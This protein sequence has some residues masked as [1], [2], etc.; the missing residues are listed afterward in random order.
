MPAA[1]TA[2]IASAENRGLALTVELPRHP[3]I[4][5]SDAS[6]ARQIL[7]N[8]LSNAI[9]YTDEGGVHVCLEPA[10]HDGVRG[11]RPLAEKNTSHQSVWPFMPAL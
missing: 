10:S 6:R 4:I 2:R 11:L 9:K 5:D 3:P 8:L 1:T 7:G